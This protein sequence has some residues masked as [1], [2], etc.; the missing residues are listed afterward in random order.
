VGPRAGLDDMERPKR[1]SKRNLER[2]VEIEFTNLIRPTAGKPSNYRYLN[3][4]LIS[5]QVE[6]GEITR[7]TRMMRLRKLQK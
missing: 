6:E 3:E 5:R 7:Y 4:G 2:P 1:V